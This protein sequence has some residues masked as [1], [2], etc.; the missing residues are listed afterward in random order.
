MALLKT[1][2]GNPAE[3]WYINIRL[4]T[5]IN[6]PIPCSRIRDLWFQA[7]GTVGFAANLANGSCPDGDREG[8]TSVRPGIRSATL[9]SFDLI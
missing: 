7:P 6:W 4:T 1:D 9:S 8:R 2:W 5:R 3:G